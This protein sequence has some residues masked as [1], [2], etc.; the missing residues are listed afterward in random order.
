MSLKISSHLFAFVIMTII[1]T[2]IAIGIVY[3][4]LG[5]AMF[6]AWKLVAPYAFL[7]VLRISIVIGVFIGICFMFSKEGIEF[8]KKFREKYKGEK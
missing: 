4:S 2:I 5:A 7:T 3:L 8:A 6:I 1:M